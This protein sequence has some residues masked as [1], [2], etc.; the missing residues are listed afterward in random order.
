MPKLFHDPRALSP[1]TENRQTLHAKRV[2]SDLR[3]TFI[4]SANLTHAAQ[5]KNIEVG[6][7][8]ENVEFAKLV[9]SHFRSLIDAHIFQE[10]PL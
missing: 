1:V 3:H 5:E 2:V 9:S 4:T 8:V 10:I 7:L 6:V